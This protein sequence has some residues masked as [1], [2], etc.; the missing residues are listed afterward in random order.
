[1]KKKKRRLV[2][3]DLIF[4][5]FTIVVLICVLSRGIPDGAQRL[6]L[7]K[8]NVGEKAIAL[9]FDGAMGSHTKKLIDAL[10]P[11][12]AKVTF[13][14]FGEDVAEDPQVVL[15]AYDEGHMIGNFTYD[16]S[17]PL[18]FMGKA[19]AKNEINKAAEVI[20]NEIG[21]RPY[22]VRVPNGFV[23]AYQLKA[24]DC[25]FV[26]W[27][28]NIYDK[29]KFTANDVYDKLMKNAADGEIIRLNINSESTVNGV[30]KAVKDLQNEGYEF[31]RVDDLLTR[32]GDKLARGM[33]Y[34]KCKH[35]HHPL[36]F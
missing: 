24:L 12:G 14:V 25:F 26:S 27:S 32:N 8:S 20:G 33:L 13:F 9:T 16:D 19:K 22:F 30:V 17:K 7:G 31:V 3:K 36:A 2:R 29:G 34:R 15:R 4:A 23:S 21:T 28:T 6:Y 18:S 1:M 35:D 10:A 11:T 5:V